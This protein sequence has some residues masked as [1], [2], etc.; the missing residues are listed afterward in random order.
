MRK[1]HYRIIN[2]TV[3]IKVYLY[4]IVF[5]TLMIIGCILLD[6]FL[7]KCWVDNIFIGL[8]TGGISSAFIVLI[9]DLS[10]TRIYEAEEKKL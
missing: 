10:N 2:T 9:M 6:L 3:P 1:D 7:K 8:G 5:S 4:I